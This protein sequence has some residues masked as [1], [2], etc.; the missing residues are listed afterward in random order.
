MQMMHYNHYAII[1]R[2]L[3]FQVSI[4]KIQKILFF[5]NHIKK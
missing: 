4:F 3:L 5:G 2:L 1:E